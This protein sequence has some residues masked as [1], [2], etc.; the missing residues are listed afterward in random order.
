VRRRISLAISLLLGIC[1][2]LFGGARQTAAAGAAS[3]D[4]AKTIVSQA[5]EAYA[6]PVDAGEISTAV[7]SALDAGVP[8]EEVRALAVGGARANRSPSE[9][10]RLVNQI[11]DFRRDDLPTSS[12]VSTV[13]EGIAKEA[14]PDMIEAALRTTKRNIVFS[15]SLAARHSTGKRGGEK[16]SDFLVR[17]L[18]LALD[19][20]FDES[21]LERVSEATRLAGSGPD[22]FFACLQ[23]LLELGGTPLERDKIAALITLAVQKRFSVKDLSRLSGLVESKLAEQEREGPKR[24][25]VDGEP[26]SIDAVYATLLEEMEK[27]AR[28]SDFFAAIGYGAQPGQGKPTAGRGPASG[29][30][31]AGSAGGSSAGSGGGGTGGGG[32][33]GGSGGGS[34]GHSGGKR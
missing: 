18:T 16:R 27:S 26:S 12:A 20:G 3:R 2:S 1:L 28:P 25:G 23:S 17:A 9:I 33:G 4:A 31:P 34:G 30:G 5:L 19:A 6:A 7:E 24:S 14:S 29:S 13:L 8:I 15:V 21:A 22:Y 10:A 32:T 11:A